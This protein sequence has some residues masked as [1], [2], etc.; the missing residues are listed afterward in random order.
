MP[1]LIAYILHP[2]KIVP[3]EYCTEAGVYVFLFYY[4]CLCCGLCVVMQVITSLFVLFQWLRNLFLTIMLCFFMNCIKRGQKENSKGNKWYVCMVFLFWSQN[5]TQTLRTKIS[6]IYAWPSVLPIHS[7]PISPTNRLSLHSDLL[8]WANN[9]VFPALTNRKNPNIIS[10]LLQ[11]VAVTLPIAFLQILY[12]PGSERSDLLLPI[13][14]YVYLWV[15]SSEAWYKHTSIV[16]SH[17]VADCFG[18]EVTKCSAGD[19]YSFH[20]AGT[21]RTGPTCAW[22]CKQWWLGCPHWT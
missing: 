16:L 11:S 3:V 9:S 17:D 5:Y 18:A 14:W 20:Q 13:Y 22:W 7:S 2:N 10:V 8:K 12:P 19:L 6:S 4:C 15:F 1:T 21:K